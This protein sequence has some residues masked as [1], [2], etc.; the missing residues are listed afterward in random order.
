M[1]T[2][3]GTTTGQK[4]RARLAPKVPTSSRA[5]SLSFLWPGLGEAY[6]GH[7]RAALAWAVPAALLVLAVVAF[8][9][10]DPASAALSLFA[11]N[12]AMVVVL[13]IGVHAAWRIASIANAWR[14][15]HRAGPRRADG[16]LAVAGVL[17]ITVLLVHLV[18]GAYVSSVASAGSRIFSAG[19]PTGNEPVLSG[20]EGDCNGDG[21]VDSHDIVLGDTN[22]D[23]VVDGSDDPETDAG[24]QAGNGNG[25]PGDPGGGIVPPPLDPGQVGV[26]PSSGPINVLFV[27]FDREVGI[28]HD[29]TDT[30]IVASYF[31]ERDTM[32]MISIARGLSR[33]PL[34]NGGI[35]PNRIDSLMTYA[36]GNPALFPEGDI[37]ALLNELDYFLGTNIPFYAITNFEGF[38]AA[39]DAVGGVDVTLTAP[40]A[41]PYLDFYLDPGLVHLTGANVLPFVRSRHGPNNNDWQRQM[42]NQS[43]LEALAKKANSPELLANLPTVLDALSRVVRTNIPSSQAGTLLTILRRANDGATVHITL[44]EPE[45]LQRIPPDEVGGRWMWQPVM[46]GVRDLSLQVFGSYSHYR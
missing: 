42:R 1:P 23:C 29:M 28:D 27:G 9:A 3:L 15:T 43:V 35:Y 16:G 24:S 14:I 19:A 4:A 7:R 26:L 34:Y 8:V 13:L 11:P 44:T 17:A 10:A 21:V 40:L 25:G 33:M 2:E 6:A 22:G 39:I 37:A 30:M 41:D 31:P 5:T 32:T 20:T 36:K 12:V 18:A 46:A 38:P 45:Y